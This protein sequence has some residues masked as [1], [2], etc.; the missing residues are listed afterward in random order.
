MK[1]AKNHAKC[2]DAKGIYS[3][4]NQINATAPTPQDWIDLVRDNETL[5][6]KLESKMTEQRKTVHD[7][8]KHFDGVWP[9]DGIEVLVWDET[10]RNFHEWLSDL[11]SRHITDCYQVCTREEFEAE[12]ERMKGDYQYEDAFGDDCEILISK[13]DDIGRIIIRRNNGQYRS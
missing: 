9:D 13:E 3:M 5:R 11:D 7:A 2:S 10:G 12:V 6:Q 4:T 8:V 1:V